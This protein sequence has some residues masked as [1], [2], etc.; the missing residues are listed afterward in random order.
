M[1][2]F[3]PEKIKEIDIEFTKKDNVFVYPDNFY[4]IRRNNELFDHLYSW[5]NGYGFVVTRRPDDYADKFYTLDEY[6]PMFWTYVKNIHL[7][8]DLAKKIN[9]YIFIFPLDKDPVL[10]Q[11]FIK[12]N[13]EKTFEHYD[14]VI[15]LWEK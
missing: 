8:A 12:P 2:Q 15:L 3:L 14:N 1:A 7:T 6:E 10:W 9:K 11:E 4:R 13:I 5:T